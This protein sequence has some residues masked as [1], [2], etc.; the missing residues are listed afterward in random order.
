MEI[1]IT[2]IL[3]LIELKRRG[4]P[5]IDLFIVTPNFILSILSVFCSL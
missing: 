5:G 1:T 3:E 4:V 2:T